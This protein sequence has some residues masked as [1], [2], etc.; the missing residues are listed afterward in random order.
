MIFY[1]T[2][3]D[4]YRAHQKVKELKDKFLREVDPTG[5]NLAVIDGEKLSAG[6]L[7][8]FFDTASLLARRRCLIIKRILASKDKKLGE[9]VVARLGRERKADDHI[10]IFLESDEPPVKNSLHLWLIT[11]AHYQKFFWL[12]GQALKKYIEDKA[13]EFN[14]SITARAVQQL[15]ERSQEDLW[16]I[17][18]DL[19]KCHAFLPSGQPIDEATISELTVEPVDAAVFPLLDSVLKGDLSLAAPRLMDYLR[20]G[21]SPQQL[22]SMLEGQLRTLLV[23]SAGQKGGHKALAGVHPYVI[24]KIAPLAASRRPADIKKIYRALSEV[25]HDLKTTSIDPKLLFI[26]FLTLAC[27]T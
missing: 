17:M 13:K 15:C 26:R 20:Q 11:H 12:K 27:E 16:Q 10:V 23:L 25:D 8:H 3:P 24:K 2:G 4:S 19:Q 18:N 5:L 22:V 21:E 9:A 14:R 6:D 7:P 1:I